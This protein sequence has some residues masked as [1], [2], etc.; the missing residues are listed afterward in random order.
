MR[1]PVNQN[2][3]V[4][5]EV[6]HEGFKSLVRLQGIRLCGLQECLENDKLEVPP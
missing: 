3:L 4:T 5:W 2:L 1:L 6:L